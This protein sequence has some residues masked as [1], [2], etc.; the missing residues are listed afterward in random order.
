MATPR[1]ISDIKPLFTNL[2]QT[3][4]YQVLFGGLPSQLISYLGNRGVDSRFIV[5]DAGLLCFN[6]S[7]PT[8][9]FATCLLYT[10][11]AADE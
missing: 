10:S 8:S 11:D 1:R 6:A 9:Q 2:A 7:L 5:E 4:H 3:S